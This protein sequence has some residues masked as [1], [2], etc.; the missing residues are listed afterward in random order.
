MGRVG[1]HIGAAA[2]QHAERHV[3]MPGLLDVGRQKEPCRQ[4]HDAAQ[5]DDARTTLVHDAPDDRAEHGGY[6][7]AEREGA[8]REAAEELGG[9]LS[10]EIVDDTAVAT[11][12]LPAA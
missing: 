4:Q 8:R 12:D 3:E 5:D 10:F 1:H 6:Q 7:K 9:S 2:D 11:L